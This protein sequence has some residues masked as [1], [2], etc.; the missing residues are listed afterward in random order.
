[1]F[2]SR[3]LLLL[4]ILTVL[5]L[6]V[7]ACGSTSVATPQPAE[8]T[9]LTALPKNSDG[10]IDI[11]VEQLA[12]ILPAKNFTLVNVHIP[13]AGDIPQTDLS[14]P[15]DQIANNLGQLPEKDAPIVLY[16]R[17]GNMSTQAAETLTGLGYTNVFE[18]DGGFNAWAA[19]GNELIM[20]R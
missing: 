16:C 18:V 7:A 15:F 1:M 3:K 6:V 17:S 14:I 19:A 5:A 2:T 4:S 11:S 8:A 13:Y 9:D 20:N 12:E 10:Y